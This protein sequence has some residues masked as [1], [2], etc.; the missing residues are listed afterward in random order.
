[1]GYNI[2]KHHLRNHLFYTGY[3]LKMVDTS[4]S[5]LQF[6]NNFY[7]VDRPKVV[8]PESF[9]DYKH[10]IELKILEKENDFKNR[11]RKFEE[12]LDDDEC[13]MKLKATTNLASLDKFK[14]KMEGGDA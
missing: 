10:K 8:T 11:R 9:T 14:I 1:M 13:S 2:Y 6:P 5:P 7:G 12:M 4:E 3:N